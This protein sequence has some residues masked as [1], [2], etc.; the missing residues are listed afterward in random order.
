MTLR[1]SEGHGGRVWYGLSTFD[2]RRRQGRDVYLTEPS[3]AVVKMNLD[4]STWTIC[5]IFVRC[6]RQNTT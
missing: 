3:V 4:A 6:A 2:N 5:T 1:E